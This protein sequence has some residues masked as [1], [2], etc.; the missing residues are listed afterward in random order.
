MPIPIILGENNTPVPSKVTR[1]KQRHN[2]SLQGKVLGTRP[3]QQ[4]MKH[5]NYCCLAAVICAP[6]PFDLSYEKECPAPSSITSTGFEEQ[7]HTMAP[8]KLSKVFFSCLLSINFHQCMFCVI[9]TK[10]SGFV[11]PA[12]LFLFIFLLT[13]FHTS[14]NMY[15]DALNCKQQNINPLYF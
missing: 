9:L 7:S 3:T 5:D 15:L 1:A 12:H 6:F 13:T 14:Q 10:P 11:Y 4:D 2:V 8:S